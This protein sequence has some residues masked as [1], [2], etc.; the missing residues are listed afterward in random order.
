MYK[1]NSPVLIVVFNRP[2]QTK[3]V[4]D[5]LRDVA[6]KRLYVA[7][8]AP[9]PD[10]TTEAEKCAKTLQIFEN[11][12]WPC[13]IFYKINNANMGS[14]TT[15]PA[16]IDWFFDNEEMGIVLEDD[17]V[18]NVSFFRYCDELLEKYRYDKRVMWINGS[19]VGYPGEIHDSSYYFSIYAISW[20]WASWRRAWSVYKEKFGKKKPGTISVDIIQQYVGKSLMP[21]LYWRY[22]FEYA[23]AIK[24]WDYRWQYAMWSSGGLACAPP[25]NLIRNVG[26]GVEAFHEGSSRDPRGNI[27]TVE[28]NESLKPPKNYVPNTRLDR[29]L[30]KNFHRINIYKILKVFIASRFPNLRNVVRA[31]R[32]K[33]I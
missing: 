31:I 18:P 19:N 13:E 29:Y 9:R 32:R 6:P 17:C 20:G 25:V 23:Y 16:A 30:N 24:N 33:S 2:Q 5:V 22:I 3:E 4:L 21:R 12:D 27:P 7:A 8:D 10:R 1:T 15:I 26:F 11:I 14:H 28:I